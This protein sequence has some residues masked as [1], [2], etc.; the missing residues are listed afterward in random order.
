MKSFIRQLVSAFLTLA[1]ITVGVIWA[2][3]L[4][5]SR[6]QNAASASPTTEVYYPPP[7]KL[8]DVGDTFAAV[9]AKH[10]P[11]KEQNRTT[12]WAHWQHFQAQFKDGKIILMPSQVPKDTSPAMSQPAF[13]AMI[14]EVYHV[15]TS[16][17]IQPD[18]LHVTLPPDSDTQ[19]ICETLANLWSHHSSLPWI[20]VES[21]RGS[22][23]LA[24]A[25]VTIP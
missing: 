5:R 6:E 21:W 12:G 16:R 13:Q 17:F 24:Q 7:L 2:V 8:P 25:T 23:R 22:Q 1:L 9:V 3:S 11:P 4:E 14:A 10:G 15:E 19:A 18:L 20:R